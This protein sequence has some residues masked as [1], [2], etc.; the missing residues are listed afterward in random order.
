MKGGAI[1]GEEFQNCF[2][3]DFRHV[4]LQI[5]D[6]CEIAGGEFELLDLHFFNLQKFNFVLAGNLFDSQDDLAQLSLE[7][8]KVQHK[9]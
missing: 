1:V 2:I 8:G 5:A 4:D 3:V 6:E 9:G 7:L